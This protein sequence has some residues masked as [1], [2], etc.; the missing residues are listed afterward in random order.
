[1]SV[2][3]IV[4]SKWCLRV[5]GGKRRERERKMRLFRKVREKIEREFDGC[6]LIRQLQ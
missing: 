5:C 4:R 3:E 2:G 1:M 6:N